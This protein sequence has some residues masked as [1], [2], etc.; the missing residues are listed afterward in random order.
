M[1]LL[2]FIRKAPEPSIQFVPS[3]DFFSRL[4][5]LRYRTFDE[6]MEAPLETAASYQ[7]LPTRKYTLS[8]KLP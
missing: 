1:K 4:H 7:P 3:R 8:V 6:L 2:S 5:D